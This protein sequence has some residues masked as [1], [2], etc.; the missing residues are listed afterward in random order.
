[1][2]Q[3]RKC[4]LCQM[5]YCSKK[6]MDEH[7][8]S[9]LHHR[10]LENLRGRDCSHECR[11][12]RVTVV[13]L[14]TYAKHI[15]S[16]LHKDKVYAWDKEGSKEED[17]EDYFDK[18][19]I[20]LI[21]QRKEQNQQD[22]TC[23]FPKE[24][25]YRRRDEHSSY[26]S[27]NQHDWQRD[28]SERSWQWPKESF[29]NSR[30][31]FLHSSLS[32]KTNRHLPGPRGRAG[33]HMN[34]QT[35]RQLVHVRVEGSW[36]SNAGGATSWHQR[37]TGRGFHWQPEGNG[38]F[39]KQHSRNCNGNWQ[40]NS[41]NTNQWNFSGNVESFPQGRNWP[42]RQCDTS[43]D[44]DSVWSKKSNTSN[45]CKERFKWKKTENVSS[46][47]TVC[48]N[49]DKNT[50]NKMDD[51]TSDNHI[52]NNFIDFRTSDSSDSSSSKTKSALSADKNSLTKDKQHRWSPY[53]LQKASD[54]N[55]PPVADKNVTPCLE[56]TKSGELQADQNEDL[57][58]LKVWY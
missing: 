37:G 15:S 48:A 29:N 3:E 46:S 8:R 32:L 18:E 5:V 45:F 50:S 23:S 12:C 43:L 4:I 54:Q 56:E 31:N 21:N 42:Q 44:Q 36:H 26:Q 7:M 52:E 20:Q 47:T 38:I 2:V 28:M 22:D 16:Q 53:P 13:G 17:E 49:I 24:Q 27:K 9:M 34:S 41:Y 39:P 40:P 55:V 10:E 51:F 1:M 25:E 35:T 33:W 11:V 19:L 14:S 30:Q 58:K 57:A 6:E